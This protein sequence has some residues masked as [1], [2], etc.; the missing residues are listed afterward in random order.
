MGRGEKK[1][2]FELNNHPHQETI[3]ATGWGRQNEKEAGRGRR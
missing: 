2:F 1:S 3:K